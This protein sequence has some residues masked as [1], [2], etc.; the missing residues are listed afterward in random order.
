MIFYGRVQAARL[1]TLGGS[2]NQCDFVLIAPFI[3]CNV[4]EANSRQVLMNIDELFN[5]WAVIWSSMVIT[6]RRAC[7]Q[8]HVNINELDDLQH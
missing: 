5:L 2:P 4:C 8:T 3:A 6:T 1:F 7:P